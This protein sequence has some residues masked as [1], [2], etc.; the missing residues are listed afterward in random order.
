MKDMKMTRVME[1]FQKAYFARAF[2][3]KSSSVCFIIK[4]QSLWTKVSKFA[5]K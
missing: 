5:S 1:L 3:R 2:F 4:R